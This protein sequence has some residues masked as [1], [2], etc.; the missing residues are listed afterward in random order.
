MKRTKYI[1][2]LTAI[3]ALS[4]SCTDFLDR[5]P[6]VNP[7]PEDY[8][9]DESQLL[10]YIDGCYPI[11]PSHGDHGDSHVDGW[12]FGIYGDDNGTDNQVSASTP[13]R[14][15]DGLWLTSTDGGDWGFGSITDLNLF[16]QYVLPKYEAGEITGDGERIR[17]YIGEAYFLRA[18]EYFNK[19]QALGDFPIVTKVLPDIESELIEA[20]KRAPRNEVARFII[21][22]LDTAIMYMDGNDLGTTRISKDAALMLKSRVALYE[23][24][25]LKYF[26]GTP[27]VPANENWP[28][29]QKEY[30]RDY[31]YPTGSVEAESAYFLQIAM[32]AS[33]D[34]ADR[35]VD[36]LTANT[37]VLQQDASEA[38]NLYMDM[39]GTEDLSTYPEVILWR[40]YDRTRM[41]H[42]AVLCAQEENNGIGLTKGLVDAFVMQNGLPI[43]ADGAN[44]GGD[45]I[46][47]T[48][49]D[50]SENTLNLDVFHWGCRINRD[51]RLSLFL[52]EPGQRNI[53][54]ENSIGT[55]Q[56]IE[57]IPNMAGT[58]NYFTGYTMRK[59]NS[60]DQI[61]AVNGGAFTGCIVFRAA[62]ALLNYIEASYELNG[63][64]DGDA[65]RYWRALR[66]R[67][68][69][70]EDYMVTV[71]AT[72]IHKE[73]TGDW[74]AYS[75][76]TELTDKILYNIRRERRCEFFGEGLRYADLKRWRAMDQ[77]KTTP[78]H[79]LA[80][81]GWNSGFELGY[82]EFT[83]MSGKNRMSSKDLGDYMYV[84][85]RRADDAAFNGWTW[86]MA[87][88]LSPIS[89]NEIRLASETGN[90]EASNIYQNPY[91][92]LQAGEAAQQ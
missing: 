71:N 61:H 63:N 66:K 77:M 1:I 23:G 73:A 55:G 10:A 26:A 38:A 39:F 16:F 14:F 91:W 84:Y 29:K 15:L 19:Y 6:V 28:G 17:H 83:E 11:M 80:I 33:K 25:W 70:E 20:S 81:K 59:G 54:I 4:L 89:I 7:A 51:T 82:I 69:V 2:G 27:F 5:R 64:I 37:G 13:D 53:L 76:G 60:Y 40:Q 65:D 88:Y 45:D 21:N 46:I 43:Y 79:H 58:T 44:Y 85:K 35:Y 90:V 34:V 78:Y 22:S 3:T 18:F 48:Y 92:S 9:S 8:F 68:G 67:A 41:T 32:E 50:D 49:L 74:G 42:N 52:K 75:R 31:N 57:P 87:H 86:K 72:D 62:E 30:S 47:P 12:D 56:P 36:Q 24:T